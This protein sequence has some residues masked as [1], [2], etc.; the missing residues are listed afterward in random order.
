MSLSVLVSE[1]VLRWYI[2]SD[3]ESSAGTARVDEPTDA[4]VFFIADAGRFLTNFCVSVCIAIRVRFDS[5]A[6][7]RAYSIALFVISMAFFAAFSEEAD[8]HRAFVALLCEPTAIF[9]AMRAADIADVETH[10]TGSIFR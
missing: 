6:A 2:I 7:S 10:S 9:S 3:D 5:D 1:L 4:D 8:A